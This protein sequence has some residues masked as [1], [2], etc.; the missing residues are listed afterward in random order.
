MLAQS[1][2]AGFSLAD[3]RQVLIYAAAA[4][5]GISRRH[6]ETNYIVGRIW[7]YYSENHQQNIRLKL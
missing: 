6:T 3:Y 7:F 2:H 5:L 4:L 1:L